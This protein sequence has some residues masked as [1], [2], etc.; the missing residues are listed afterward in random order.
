MKSIVGVRFKAA[1]KIYDFECGSIPVNRGDHV[2]VETE[3][4]LG[5][6]VVAVLPVPMVEQPYSKPLKKLY[7]LAREED[8]RQ[9]EKIWR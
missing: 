9:R 5:L 3:K 7:R 8:F 1:G 4:G 6:G 2:I